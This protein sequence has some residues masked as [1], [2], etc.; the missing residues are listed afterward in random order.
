MH[1][2]N[3]RTKPP[4]W[5]MKKW[6]FVLG[7]ETCVSFTNSFRSRSM[8]VAKMLP[9]LPISGV[10]SRPRSH[11]ELRERCMLFIPQQKPTL[12]VSILPTLI[13]S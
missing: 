6:P 12:L 5:S 4:L 11:S 9:A 7:T 10:A 3:K 13:T 8:A 1:L 2:D